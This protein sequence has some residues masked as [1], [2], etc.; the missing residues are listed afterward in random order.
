MRE[1]EFSVQAILG[2]MLDGLIVVD[3]ERRIQ[4]MNPHFRVCLDREQIE[5][6]TPLFEAVRDA[7]VEH[8]VA[9]TLRQAS[10]ARK[11]A[12]DARHRA[13]P[14]RSKSA[15]LPFAKDRSAFA[16]P[17]CCS[18]ISHSCAEPTEVRRDFVANVSHELRTPLSIFRGYLETLLEDR[19]SRRAS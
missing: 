9:E 6:G 4:M 10:R 12:C 5:T 19:I 15:P 17:F 14:P 18:A 13:K 2:A 3:E 11:L 1:G 16:A 7:S 8:A